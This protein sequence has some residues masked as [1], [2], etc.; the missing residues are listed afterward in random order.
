MQDNSG[1]EI[2]LIVGGYELSGWDEASLDNAIDTPADSWSVTL[3][4]PVYD[5]LPSSVASGKPV[6]F[7]YGNELVLT[8]IIDKIS[9]AV[10]RHGR[11]LQVSGRDLVGQ[12]IDCSV[13]I[14]S[15]RQVT[16]DVLLNKY[17]KSGDLGSLF[18]SISIQDNSALKNKVSVEPGEALW[19]A[20]NKAAQVT[21]QYVWLEADGTLKVGDPF[22][23]PYHIK[24]DLLLMYDGNDNNVLEAQ[25]D[26]DV[27]NVYS[28]IKILS[29]DGNA[30]HIL[31]E[32]K[33]STSYGFNRLKI[34]SLGDVETKAEAD[35]ALKKI[36]A[37]NNL[38]AYSL[39]PTVKGWQ[40]DNKVWSTGWYLNLKSDVLSRATAK[41][42]VM[43][44]TLK[45]SRSGG[46]TTE[47]K[48]KR[49][50][51]WAQPLVHKDKQTKAA[52]KRHS[53]KK[54]EQQ[55]EQTKKQGATA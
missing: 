43:G 2:R 1:N 37:D 26:E 7:Y 54:A 21:G 45:L 33:T 47:L 44:R 13:P 25:Y 3:F 6:K 36:Q 30:N 11:A 20:I 34:V 28:E 42:A 14:F 10:S 35:A 46:Q 32:G 18:K 29:Q 41:W 55:T 40:I 52:K 9:E 12:L 49:Q 19:D 24:T 4:N 16:L 15:G 51:D 38:E 39:N 53:K 27:S 22:A 17:V 8:G 48:L 50:G 23:N 5:Q 31:S